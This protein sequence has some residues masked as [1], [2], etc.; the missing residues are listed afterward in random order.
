MIQKNKNERGGE[1]GT[2]GIEGEMLTGFSSENL[3]G[4]GKQAYDQKGLQH[5]RFRMWRNGRTLEK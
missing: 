3:K 2:Y 1:C 4:R 5:V